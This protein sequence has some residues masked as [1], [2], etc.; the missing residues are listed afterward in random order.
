MVYFLYMHRYKYTIILFITFLIAWAIGRLGII[1][2]YAA[3]AAET[4][5]IIYV[6]LSGAMYSFSFTAG[7]SVLLFSELSITRD[8]VLPLS[9][10]AA[11]GGLL[12]DLLI[13]RFIK[14]VI[15]NELGDHAKK[16]IA[17]ATKTKVAKVCLGVLGGVIIASPLPDEIG[18]T[19]MGVSKIK[20]WELVV[21]T[22]MLDTLGCYLIISAI[23]NI[24]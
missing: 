19:F 22:Y 5:E 1:D 24:V 12:S 13:F 23:A 7:L 18:L 21:L 3:K 17:K 11:L 15:L 4:N 2:T 8:M 14:D 6:F 20:F 10:I 16:M 9:L